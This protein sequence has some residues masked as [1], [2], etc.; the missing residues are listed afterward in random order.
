MSMSMASVI[1]LP[2]ITKLYGQSQA[3]G[4]HQRS[5]R[6]V[7]RT[8]F[9]LNGFP[10]LRKGKGSSGRRGTFQKILYLPRA[11][12]NDPAS[13]PEVFQGMYGPWSID[14]NDVREVLLYRGGL[15]TTAVTFLIAASRAF[16][17]GDNALSS[18]I[19]QNFDVLYAVGAGGLGLSL[20]LIHIYVTPIK[21]MLQ[22]L[23]GAGVLGSV[24][25]ALKFAAPEDEGLVNFV[26]ENRWAIWLVGPLFASLTGLV[27]KE[28]L[29]YGKLEAALLVFVIPAVLLG[30]LSGLTDNRAE[31]LLL[32]AWMALYSIF[33]ARKFSQPIKDDLG[34]KSIFMFNALS[35]EEKQR[36]L[37]KLEANRMLNEQQ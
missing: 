33:T 34:D 8:V 11:V 37:E 2:A 9:S 19:G 21:R 27:F 10:C 28:G 3:I 36:V 5:V 18:F 17:P 22:L 23:W 25:V 6:G 4:V 29:C 32:F 31:S 26:I 30:H 7:L 14:S 35:E 15:V 24:L 20:F 16:L 1:A 12:S 13:A